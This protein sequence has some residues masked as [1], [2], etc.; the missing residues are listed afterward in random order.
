MKST[1]SASAAV[2]LTTANT[3]TENVWQRPSSQSFQ[4]LTSTTRTNHFSWDNLLAKKMGTLMLLVTASWGSWESKG[5]RQEMTSQGQ[6]PE[7]TGCPQHGRA[8]LEQ[9]AQLP[10]SP[11][12]AP[13]WPRP[14]RISREPL[15]L[16]PLSAN[17]QVSP[18]LLSPDSGVDM[19]HTCAHSDLPAL[20][21]H[22]PS[23]LWRWRPP[24][25]HLWAR[26]PILPQTLVT[27]KA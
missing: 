7:Q 8:G 9:V 17:V 1:R 16:S 15:L 24:E 5:T 20:F 23:S 13:Q 27:S 19:W 18:A 3:F 21:P 4:C 25:P 2:T 11:P 26:A 6:Q 10:A 14:P 12:P 22:Q